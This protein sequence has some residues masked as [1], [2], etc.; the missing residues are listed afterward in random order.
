MR[1][2]WSLG[3]LNRTANL[4]EYVV[5]IRPNQTNRTH[6]NHENYSQH[7]RVLRDVLATLVV[8]QPL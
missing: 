6:D 3:L 2:Y 4:R 7:D 1:C 8:P 5:R